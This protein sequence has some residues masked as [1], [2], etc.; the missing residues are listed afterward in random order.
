MVLPLRS[1]ERC[2]FSLGDWFDPSLVN[3][4]TRFSV[5][6]RCPFYV[7]LH[8]PFLLPPLTLVACSL[9]L[10]T[11]RCQDELEG[12]IPGAFFF[13]IGSLLSFTVY[14]PPIAQLALLHLSMG[15]PAASLTG[16]QIC[17]HKYFTDLRRLV[18][19]DSS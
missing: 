2:P 7:A 13:L 10:I 15:D 6:E 1:V 17:L 3:L 16:E 11:F 18:H 5:L 12:S 14:P 4:S 19:D 9:L 8:R